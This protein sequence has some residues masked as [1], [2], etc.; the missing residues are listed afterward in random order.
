MQPSLTY[1][2]DIHLKKVI[3]APLE[4]AFAAWVEPTMLAKWWGPKDFENPVCEIDAQ[5]GGDI[6]IEMEGPDGT[7]YPMSGTIEWIDAP[8]TL[9]FTTNALDD[10]GRIML[11]DLNTVNFTDINGE[12]TI[13]IHVEVLKVIKEGLKHVEGMES[14]WRQSLD[15]LEEVMKNL[16]TN[17][18]N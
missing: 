5:K 7:I 1:K 16:G 18:L 17:S 14:G 10:N 9:L 3:R 8:K 15:R 13:D 2:K 6:Y 11:T 4:R 12:T